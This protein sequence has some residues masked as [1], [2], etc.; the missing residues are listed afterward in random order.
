MSGHVVERFL[1]DSVNGRLDRGPRAA[2]HR[3]LHGDRKS[4]PLGDP[5]SQ[6]FDG[7]EQ[8]QVIEDRRTELMRETSQLLR[9]LVE[10][11]SDFLKS[12]APSRRQIQSKL[13]ERDIDGTE[14]LPSLVV[15]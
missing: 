14:K 9:D 11:L 15:E 5:F 12:L 3:A 7:R 10:E 4:R 8:P 2:L 13:L 1:N 6:E